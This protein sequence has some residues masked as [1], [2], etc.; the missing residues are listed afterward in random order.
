M[1]DRSQRRADALALV[2]AVV[3]ALIVVLPGLVLIAHG[4]A[5][6]ALRVEHGET[7]SL[8]TYARWWVLPPHHFLTDAL[9]GDLDTFYNFL[10]DALLNAGSAIVRLPPMAFQALVYAP[11]LAFLYVWGGYRALVAALEDRTTAALAAGLAAFTVNPALSRLLLGAHAHDTLIR[12]VHVPFHALPL[13]TGQ[14]LGWVLFFPSAALLFAAREKFSPGRGL[15][16][17]LFFGLLFLAHTLTFINVAFV[18]VAYLM[19]RRLHERPSGWRGRIWAAGTILLLAVF[20]WRAWVRPPHSFLV[21]ASLWILAMALLFFTDTDRRFYFW[22]Y[23]P[24]AVVAFPY[25][26]HLARNAPYLAGRDGT[27]AAVSP[28]KLFLFFLLQWLLAIAAWRWAPRTAGLRWGAV[29]LAANLFLAANHLW[30]WGNHPY[31]FAINLVFPLAVLGAY[32]LRYAPRPV[33][34]V[35]GLAVIGAATPRI[36]A[37]ARNKR[38]LAPITAG[39]HESQA[40]LDALHS[41]T[42]A[43][44][45]RESRMLTPPE[46][47]Y[48][49]GLVQSS[50]LLGSSSLRGFVPDYRYVLWNERY[51][52]RLALFCFLFPYPHYDMHTGLRA[53]ADLPVE[54][55]TFDITD[56]RIRT[57]V[58]P[59]Y[60]LRY[61]AAL[62][63]PFSGPL[64]DAAQLNRWPLLAQDGDSRFHRIGATALPGVARLGAGTYSASGFTVAVD[65]DEPGL[66]RI[67]IGGRKLHD[68]APS[69]TMDGRE[70]S[71]RERNA[72]W[73]VGDADLAAGRH[74]LA[75]PRDSA[76]WAEECDFLY[77]LAIVTEKDYGRYFDDRAAT[78]ATRPAS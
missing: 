64:A 2:L 69:V 3:F 60:R 59:V 4:A 72:H 18:G 48:P 22:S 40:F 33:A 61:G 31:R 8:T 70:I 47:F 66:Q 28:F 29:M 38:L 74:V 5:P 23:I 13:G 21:L 63:Y 57:E 20:A 35:L 58:L 43:E 46:F 15:A 54:P 32:G 10:S 6:R 7:L 14:S 39:S 37:T 78:P 9:S 50:A 62:G 56:R 76:H 26:L 19:V 73:I 55:K 41:A 12:L 34:W 75:L 52:N 45:D 67:V 25:A 71:V 1:N 11:L 44:P 36:V 16:H 30:A 77:F 49:E 68:R 24:A 42:D 65:V 53:C 17:G 51:L 27:V